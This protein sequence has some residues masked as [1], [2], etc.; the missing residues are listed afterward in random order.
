MKVY[1]CTLKRS[2]DR[3]KPLIDQIGSMG[4]KYELIYGVD[5]VSEDIIKYSNTINQDYFQKK[6]KRKLKPT[7]VACTLSHKEMW[8]R[9]VDSQESAAI[10]LEDDAFFVENPSNIFNELI[11]LKCDMIVLGYPSRT[12]FDSKCSKIMEPIYS[13]IFCSGNYEVGRS[14]QKKNFGLMA[15]YL[16]RDAA[17]RL[18]NAERVW[19]VAD[20]YELIASQVSVYH[21]RPYL[22]FERRD[23]I[24]SI[25]NTYRNNQGINLFRKKISRIFRGCFVYLFLGILSRIGFR[26]GYKL[27]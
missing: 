11:N 18:L 20:D 16:T 8:Q 19:S 5:G 26:P 15:Y 12:Q 4:I 9:F 10:F 3:L 2:G 13:K 23:V 14:P 6:Y 27:K 22:C 25:N 21:I 17:L 24:S 7:E 1:I